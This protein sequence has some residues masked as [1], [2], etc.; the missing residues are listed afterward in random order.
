MFPK[1]RK[2]I[3]AYKEKFCTA[4]AL[5]SWG[6]SSL[7]LNELLVVHVALQPNAGYG[8]LIHEVFEITHTTRHSR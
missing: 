3:C 7:S 5:I 8:L 2:Y 1:R 4:P 6:F